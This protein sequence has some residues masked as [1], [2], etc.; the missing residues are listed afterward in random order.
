MDYKVKKNESLNGHDNEIT[1]SI[2][3]A[4]TDFFPKDLKTE[5]SSGKIVQTG[6]KFGI[7]G[8]SCPLHSEISYT[9]LV[10]GNRKQCRFIFDILEE[11]KYTFTLSND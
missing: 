3:S 2:K 4:Y 6:N 1:F 7:S 8:Y 11:G 9:I 10:G 5:I